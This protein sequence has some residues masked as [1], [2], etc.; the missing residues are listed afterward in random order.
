MPYVPAHRWRDGRLGAAVSFL[1]TVREDELP[2]QMQN[3]RT[4]EEVSE[5]LCVLVSIFLVKIDLD[6]DKGFG[7]A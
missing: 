4:S 1:R 3:K 6:L 2:F 7:F 5:V